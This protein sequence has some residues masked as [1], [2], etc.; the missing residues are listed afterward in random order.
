MLPD[1]VRQALKDTKLIEPH[2]KHGE[3]IARNKVINGITERAMLSHPECFQGEALWDKFPE[4]F[5]KMG[6]PFIKTTLT[7]EAVNNLVDKLWES[8]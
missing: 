2:K 7:E 3:S 8:L 4:T 1:N 5:N 6:N